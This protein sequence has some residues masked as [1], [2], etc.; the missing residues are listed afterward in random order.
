VTQTHKSQIEIRA[1]ARRVFEVLSDPQALIGGLPMIK[2]V[3]HTPDGPMRRGT[4]IHIFADGGE[5]EEIKVEAEVTEYL[6]PRVIETS[7][8]MSLRHRRDRAASR[9]EL[10]QYGAVTQL[11]VTSR[12]DVDSWGQWVFWPITRLFIDWAAK[13]QLK[14]IRG[15]AETT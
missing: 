9:Y 15:I 7:G 8:Y 2:R 5:G 11:T 3:E 14:Q 6:P 1:S 12:I 4:R 10:E 13:R